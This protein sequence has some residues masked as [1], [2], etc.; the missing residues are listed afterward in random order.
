MRRRYTLKKCRFRDQYGNDSWSV[1][2]NGEYKGMGLY[3]ES[4]GRY[5]LRHN[6]VML[7]S[8]KSLAD[9]RRYLNLS[10]LERIVAAI[11]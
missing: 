2:D 9:A 7:T 4:R 1:I 5:V 6:G 8:Y 10:E 3:H 11:F